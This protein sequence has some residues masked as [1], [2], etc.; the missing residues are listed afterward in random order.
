MLK[1]NIPQF[2]RYFGATTAGPGKPVWVGIQT[3]ARFSIVRL[4]T[5]GIPGSS[6]LWAP[7]VYSYGTALKVL[8]DGSC[9]LAAYVP[10]TT[11][12]IGNVVAKF[13]AD[14]SLLWSKRIAFQ[15][16]N[17]S[18]A[19]NLFDLIPL[20]GG[21]MLLVG[22]AGEQWV[23]SQPFAMRLSATGQVLWARDYP[24][25]RTSSQVIKA[26]PLLNSTD[27]LLVG[28][29]NGSQLFQLRLDAQ[30]GVVWARQHSR[31][32]GGV[33]YELQPLA[34]GN[35]ALVVANGTSPGFGLTELTPNG[36]AVRAY[37]YEGIHVAAA[38]VQLQPT[39][40]AAFIGRKFNQYDGEDLYLCQLNAQWQGT[41]VR[42]LEKDSVQYRFAA[43]GRLVAPGG[44]YMYGLGHLFR[45]LN[46]DDPRQFCFF[47]IDV[48][49]GT[50]CNVPNNLPLF[51]PTAQTPTTTAL[52]IPVANV[53]NATTLPYS[54]PSVPLP[55]V[56]KRGC[57]Q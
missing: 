37:S 5:S 18:Y 30:G 49:G 11:E 1:T 54:L 57:P 48:N 32:I 20:P 43:L 34:N 31:T 33:D 28:G 53:I 6:Q 27:V 56:G 41:A 39:G 3:T 19:A 7:N 16:A 40:E 46:N 38:S 2:K 29:L 22:E 12:V 25:P 9:L 26:V 35:V 44:Q 13:A 42:A 36:T 50:P 21:D 51:V 15:Q 4:D 45:A 17:T 23:P 24:M 47:K 52:A 55:L 10:N 14:G 8:P